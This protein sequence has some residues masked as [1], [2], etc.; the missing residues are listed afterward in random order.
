MLAALTNFDHPP[1]GGHKNLRRTKG[2]NPDCRSRRWTR[3]PGA[4]RSAPPMQMP[5]EP[6]GAVAPSLPL[7][8]WGMPTLG[9]PGC[10][11]VERDRES[12]YSS[13]IDAMVPG[14]WV[15]RPRDY[16]RAPPRD[17]R[18]PGLEAAT[19][20]P[21]QESDRS[22]QSATANSSSLK[23]W[24]SFHSRLIERE[25][26]RARLLEFGAVLHPT[27]APKR[28]PV[29]LSRS[30]VVPTSPEQLSWLPPLGRTPIT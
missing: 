7:P 10:K 21:R 9:Q 3:A 13:R 8:E 2:L 17:P 15:L 5:G 20:Q 23:S 22:W 12:S 30:Q 24:E 4:T 19:P 18:L 26:Q 14:L 28:A 27:H 1:P 16:N 11:T 29:P 25:D 6:R